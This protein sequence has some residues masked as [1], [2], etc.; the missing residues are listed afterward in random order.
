M[1]DDHAG[2]IVV[3][4]YLVDSKKSASHVQL[5][6]SGQSCAFPLDGNEL[7][8]WD[9]KEPPHQ[10]F[11]KLYVFFVK[12]QKFAVKLCSSDAVWYTGLS[13]LWPLP[14]PSTGSRHAGSMAMAHGP[15]RSA[16]CGIFPD[17]DTNPRPLYRQVDSQPL[18]H[19]GG[20]SIVLWGLGEG[21]L[22]G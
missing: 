20:P 13:L 4:K 21:V 6:C 9:T 15:S 17:W 8:V 18:R 1:N 11:K 5:A 7:C 12:S 3:E 22:L 14:L 2:D 16:A 10:A 19:Q